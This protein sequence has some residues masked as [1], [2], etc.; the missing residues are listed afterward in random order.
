MMQV[1]RNTKQKVVGAAAVA[2][3]LAAG[4]IAAVTAT[5]HSAVPKKS[6]AHRRAHHGGMRQLAVAASYLGVSPA[7]LS[8]ELSAHKTLAQIADAT[9]GRSAAGLS[10]ALVA[11]RKS[12]LDSVAAKLP[13]R[14]AAQVNRVGGPGGAAAHGKAARHRRGVAALFATPARLGAVAA[15]YLQVAPKQLLADLR[16]GK[17]LAQVADATPGKSQAGLV[18]ALA[19]ARRAKVERASAAG[20]VP[21]ARKAKRLARLDKHIGA[22]VQ[23]QF[24]GAGSP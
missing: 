9:S 15:G 23:R 18:S 17:T 2:A 13:R 11:A 5:G 4:S 1:R 16:A 14:V 24:A 20:R 21:A 7:Q 22:L 8:S 19:A 3:L 10:A 6:H 12:R